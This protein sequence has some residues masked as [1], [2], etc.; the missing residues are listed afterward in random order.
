MQTSSGET[1]AMMSVRVDTRGTNTQGNTNT[2]I[3]QVAV[4]NRSNICRLRVEGVLHDENSSV[5]KVVEGIGV[6]HV[7]APGG[8][9][10][11]SGNLTPH[12]TSSYSFRPDGYMLDCKSLLSKTI[13]PSSNGD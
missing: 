3:L 11:G 10:R 13:R 8:Q 5:L 6:G 7:L 2:G 9:F 4:Q 12:R 1:I